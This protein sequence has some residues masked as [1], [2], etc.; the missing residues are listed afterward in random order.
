MLCSVF[1][2]TDAIWTSSRYLQIDH[3]PLR[4]FSRWPFSGWVENWHCETV[5]NHPGGGIQL[6]KDWG[7]SYTSKERWTE[8][9]HS[10]KSNQNQSLFIW[11][12]NIKSD[13]FFA[14]LWLFYTYFLRCCVSLQSASLLVVTWVGFH[15][16]MLFRLLSLNVVILSVMI[17][18]YHQACPGHSETLR[19]EVG[20]DE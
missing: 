1:I 4:I 16:F 14:V 6:S 8:V 18:L 11:W 3:T 20:E 9:R 17:F 12:K 10:L 5:G 19:T 7:G 15:V 13:P 2:N